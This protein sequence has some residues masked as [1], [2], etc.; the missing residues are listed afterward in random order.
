MDTQATMDY[1]REFCLR[2][3]N[4]PFCARKTKAQ[5]RLLRAR[6][7]SCTPKSGCTKRGVLDRTKN[8]FA[9]SG[10]HGKRTVQAGGWKAPPVHAVLV[11]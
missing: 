10:K 3:G 4:A 8:T 2:L 5:K 9:I 1:M 11:P 7:D 6:C